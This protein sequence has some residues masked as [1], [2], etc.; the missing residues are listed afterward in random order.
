[1]ESTRPAPARRTALG[2]V[3]AAC[4]LGAS[5]RSF[6]N[7]QGTS[8]EAAAVPGVQAPVGPL[9]LRDPESSSV[10]LGRSAGR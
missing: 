3:L 1:M 5:G 4:V 10:I 2:A 7:P 9:Q 6:V 8:H